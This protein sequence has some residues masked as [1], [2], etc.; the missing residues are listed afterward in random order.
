MQA[1]G[2]D[3]EVL[4]AAYDWLQQGHEVVLVTVLQTWGSSPRPPGSLLVM[5]GDGIHTGSVSGGCVEED[6]VQRYRNRQLSDD[7]P[8]RVDYGVNRADASRFGLPCGGRLELLIEKINNIKEIELL[9]DALHDNKIIARRVDLQTG[10][11]TLEVAD[12]EQDFEYSDRYAQKVLGPQWHML[13]IGAGHLSHYV[14][15]VALLLGYRVTVCDP[16][17]EY[18]QNWQLQ[19]TEVTSLMPD[20]AVGQYA[21]QARSIV[22]ALTH[23]PKLD[24]MALLDAL[25]SPAFYV[26]AIG[27][28][29]NCELRRQRLRELGLSA[30]QIG[31]LHAPVGIAIGSH[32]PA[33]IAVSILAEI[34]R[35]RNEQRVNQERPDVID[36]SIK[37]SVR[38]V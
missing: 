11:V 27:S 38:L 10:K 15:Q 16:R 3:Q 25:D 37:Q 28:K 8:T 22:V 23:D 1:Y 20:D 4:Q 26:G 35:Q 6:L 13:L 32:T 21:Q 36:A 18:A 33:E 12:A 14:S 17:E 5:R 34:T 31:R 9:L 30:E 29:R 24:D 2:S 7:Y 19:G